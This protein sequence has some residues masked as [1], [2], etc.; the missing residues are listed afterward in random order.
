VQLYFSLMK[1]MNL[2][3]DAT[4]FSVLLRAYGKY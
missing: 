4:T 3:P 2:K 1:K